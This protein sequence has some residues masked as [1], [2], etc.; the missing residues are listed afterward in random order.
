MPSTPLFYIRLSLFFLSLWHA[1][2][3]SP[4]S[5]LAQSTIPVLHYKISGLQASV[6]NLGT[7][8]LLSLSGSGAAALDC[9]ARQ[10]S[11]SPLLSLP[12]KS[13]APSDLQV[14][15]EGDDRCLLWAVQDLAG[16]CQCSPHHT[17]VTLWKENAQSGN[18]RRGDKGEWAVWQKKGGIAGVLLG[19]E[20]ARAG[21]TWEMEIAPAVW[22]SRNFDIHQGKVLALN[23]DKLY[24]KDISDPK[25]AKTQPSVI[26]L[27]HEY[28]DFA[29][30][31]EGKFIF[32]RAYSTIIVSPEFNPESAKAVKLNQS[33]H[34]ARLHRAGF[35]NVI[36]NITRS[37]L[38][39]PE[40]FTTNTTD[41]LQMTITQ[42]PVLRKGSN[43]QVR[44]VQTRDYL[45]YLY[46]SKELSKFVDVFVIGS[47]LG[48]SKMV[49]GLPGKAIGIQTRFQ[50]RFEDMKIV[51]TEVNKTNPAVVSINLAYAIFFNSHIR[52][53]ALGENR[54]VSQKYEIQ[55]HGMRYNLLID[56]IERERVP[57]KDQ[58]VDEIKT[59]VGGKQ[60]VLTLGIT[61]IVCFLCVLIIIC[62]VRTHRIK[63]IQKLIDTDIQVS[64]QW[65]FPDTANDTFP[66]VDEKPNN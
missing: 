7:H 22:D 28:N 20:C 61:L 17:P 9:S 47:T 60:F 55:T 31:R 33:Y 41:A 19:E 53:E 65:D 4:L 3:H 39:D 21:A 8:P 66:P 56:V 48:G 52:C 63:T 37:E 43:T 13:S 45:Y 46:H 26:Y 51:F 32:I 23:R 36:L 40:F 15:A 27:K 11:L 57:Q 5:S 29:I 64:G 62:W 49:K 10:P 42:I 14:A 44:F 54:N 12:F 50:D 24:S 34:H 59:F 38:A 2:V 6:L 35:R 25:Q 18:Q 58:V 16:F 1:S 30:N